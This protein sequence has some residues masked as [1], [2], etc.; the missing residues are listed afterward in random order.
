MLI[1]DKAAICYQTSCSQLLFNQSVCFMV[2]DDNLLNTFTASLLHYNSLFKKKKKKSYLAYL[3]LY[4][5]S[6]S[7]ALL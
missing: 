1:T 5:G 3:S 2:F 7:G 6:E 4:T